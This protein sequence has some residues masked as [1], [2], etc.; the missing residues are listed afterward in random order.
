MVTINIDGEEVDVSECAARSCGNLQPKPIRMKPFGGIPSKLDRDANRDAHKAFFSCVN[1]KCNPNNTV[2]NTSSATINANPSG[3]I[4]SGT[5]KRSSETT[6]S[7]YSSE[8]SWV[9]RNKGI[10]YIGGG[11]A[12][13]GITV[14]IVYMVKK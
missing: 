8:E 13:V 9:S 12:A 5:E 2:V 10:L 1:S 6:D 14:L 7:E 11:L 3:S 4:S